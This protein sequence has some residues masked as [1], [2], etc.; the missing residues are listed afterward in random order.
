MAKKKTLVNYSRPT[1]VAHPPD[2]KVSRLM[3]DK[4]NY[5]RWVHTNIESKSMKGLALEVGAYHFVNECYDRQITEYRE[6]IERLHDYKLRLIEKH[7][8]HQ[9]RK[10][11][12]HESLKLAIA[13]LTKKR[14]EAI[15]ST[16]RLLLP[17]DNEQA[18]MDRIRAEDRRE[19]LRMILQQRKRRFLQ[20]AMAA[21]A[22]ER[23][24][25]RAEFESQVRTDFDDPD[26]IDEAIAEYDRVMLQFSPMEND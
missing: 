19:N 22:S 3:Q 15:H 8:E 14:I 18:Q 23:A 16:K 25:L 21:E 5:I 1:A 24:R 13:E 2:N 7:R 11:I 10:T 20:K 6:R 17:T 26:L 9:A 12:E 4:L